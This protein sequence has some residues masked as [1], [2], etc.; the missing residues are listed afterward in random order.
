MW[1][2]PA[3][4]HAF[5][6]FGSCTMFLSQSQMTTGVIEGTVYDEQGA[7]V[8][9]AR[10]E[11]KH[12]GIGISRRVRSD[13][14]GHYVGILLPIGNYEITARQDGFGTTK[15]IGIRL[16]V[17]QTQRVDLPLTVAPA[18]TTIEVTDAEPLLE[19]RTEQSTLIDGIAL[20]GL[21]LNGRRF[22]DLA[23]LA[24]MV[25][26]EK[27][28]GQLSLSGARG[29]NSSI[30][31]DGAN[32]YQPFFGGQRGGERSPFAYVMSQEAIHEFRVVHGNFPAEFGGSAGGLVNV[33]TK[34][35]S[36]EYH[37]SGFYYLRHKEFAVKDFVGG[38]RAPTRQQFGFAVGGPVVQGKTF[39]YTVYDQQKEN[40]PLTVRFSSTS[41]LPQDIVN[42][43]GTFRSTNDINTYLFKLDSQ[44]TPAHTLSARYN[45]SRNL[46][47]N[48]TQVGVT[49]SA[50]ENNGTE[51]NHIHGVVASL[52]SVLGQKA[53]NEF[54][55]Q[56]AHE[57]R[58][59]I[60][61]GEDSSFVSKAGPEVRIGNCCILG[62]L[63]P[64]PALTRDHQWQVSD[65]FSVLKGS[66]H[67]KFG[68]ES[69]QTLVDQTFRGNWRGLY[70]FSTIESYLRSLHREINPATGQPYSADLF[71]VYF[72]DG[73]FNA[74]VWQHAGFV[75]DAFKVSSRLHVNLGLRY[76]AS[77]LAQ[78]PEPNLLLPQTARVPSEKQMWQPRVGLSWDIF[79]NGK[80]SLRLGGG[81]FYARTPLLLLNQA[82]TSNG[83][84][85]V[86][87]TLNLLSPQIDAVQ[88]FRPE[89]VFPFVPDTSRAANASYFLGTQVTSIRPD[90]SFFAPDF[91]NP[92]SLQYTAGLERIVRQNLTASLDYLHVNTVYLER[93]RDVN[94]PAPVLQLDNSL[95]PTLRPRFNL[96][97]RPNGNFGILRQQ[98]S[99]AR[100]NYDAITLTMRSAGVNKLHFL[101]HYTLAYNRDDDSNERNFLGISYENAFDLRS[102]YGWSRNDI[103]HRWV[104]SGMYDL[105]WGLQLGSIIEWR[106]NFPFTAFTGVDSNL[107]GQLTDRPIINGSPLPRNSFRHPNS[108]NHDLRLSKTARIRETH[109]ISLVLD[110]FNLW[111]RSNFL[112]ATSINEQGSSIFLGSLWGRSQTPLPTF[113]SVRLSDGSINKNGIISSLPF[114]LQVA[115]KYSF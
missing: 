77:F 62:G 111:N 84:P 75:Q 37:G 15:R 74:T 95:P 106:T 97:A 108:F 54:R 67:F 88:R 38:D 18:E 94:L 91:R 27:E 12:L 1:K 72:G 13:H 78:P 34:S 110:I 24:P 35:G 2:L 86:G 68:L 79:G 70:F 107:D 43:E 73:R 109:Q 102:E 36:S 9:N 87:V 6:V 20:S 41:G 100:A 101:S 29:I 53:F 80:T 10:V 17:G 113:R 103:R 4:L 114:Q 16:A 39:F 42:K 81:L 28:R 45:Y 83:S 33:V 19:Y 21:P 50:L 48:G 5:I 26:Q 93:I 31:I 55:W 49:G 14:T 11:F 98:E 46:A 71:R 60:N 64:L 66:H 96:G 59:R 112:F 57:A 65:N 63:S 61:N 25:Y 76:E 44:L 22:L 8:P 89:F 30:S 105:P 23:L 115:V 82:F 40:Q 69:S 51:R 52:N 32:F 3:V 56:W 58:P 90:A 92:R 104:F 99:T 47:E 7:V 85:N